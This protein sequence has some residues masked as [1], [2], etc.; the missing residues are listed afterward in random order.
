GGY[1]DMNMLGSDI[2]NNLDYGLA[3]F[4]NLYL[5]R[6]IMKEP[7]VD[8]DKPI[9]SRK[10]SKVGGYNP[11]TQGVYGL[12][13][14]LTSLGINFAGLE[15]ASNLI[16]FAQIKSTVLGI[17]VDWGVSF[18]TVG[19]EGMGIVTGLVGVVIGI[20][21]LNV[22][23]SQV[24][25]G[26]THIGKGTKNTDT[27][28][29]KANYKA[30]AAF[31]DGKQQDVDAVKAVG[32][33]PEM[34]AEAKK[35]VDNREFVR[36]LEVLE[37]IPLVER[38]IAI[39]DRLVKGFDMYN[40]DK[41]DIIDLFKARITLGEYK[42]AIN[43]LAR[44]FE[45]FSKDKISRNAFHDM[46]RELVKEYQKQ[47]DRPT[48]ILVTEQLLFSNGIKENEAISLY[49]EY[50]KLAKNDSAKKDYYLGRAKEVFEKAYKLM[51]ASEGLQRIAE[52]NNL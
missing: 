40:F 11:R 49:N 22:I 4:K 39:E 10:L 51:P 46:V 45:F 14:T 38:A 37:N 6:K 1:S 25:K 19:S 30:M 13:R 27:A 15:I 43:V 42:N 44:G 23:H 17:L 29:L 47:G 48:V 34:E 20:T 9:S 12:G 35:Y 2:K 5:C 28:P 24:M 18:E 41:E 7:R 32:T 31:F 8:L 36:Q 21:A 26:L 33:S 16:N 50:M 3:K 52:K